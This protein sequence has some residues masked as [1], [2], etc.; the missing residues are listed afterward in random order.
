M[1]VYENNIQIFADANDVIVFD[2]SKAYSYRTDLMFCIDLIQPIYS[3]PGFILGL[4]KQHHVFIKL[5]DGFDV[6]TLTDNIQIKFIINEYKITNLQ[7][8]F[9]LKKREVI[10]LSASMFDIAQTSFN[11]LLFYRQVDLNILEV[12]NKQ[13]QLYSFLYFLDQ[14]QDKKQ[15]EYLCDRLMTKGLSVNINLEKSSPLFLTYQVL[16]CQDNQLEI[17]KN[18]MNFITKFE[19][20]LCQVNFNIIKKLLI[21]VIKL[22]NQVLTSQIVH[23]FAHNNELEELEVLIFQVQDLILFKCYF[24]PII[25]RQC[26]DTYSSKLIVQLFQ[27]SFE[28]AVESVANITIWAE[29]SPLILAA[30]SGNQYYVQKFI[31]IDKRN[32]HIALKVAKS[33]KIIDMLIPNFSKLVNYQPQSTKLMELVQ[34]NTLNQLL[35]K[36]VLIQNQAGIQDQSGNYASNIVINNQYKILE[37]KNLLTIELKLFHSQQIMNMKISPFYSIQLIKLK[38]QSTPASLQLY[39]LKQLDD[40]Q[41]A[42][43][44]FNLQTDVFGMSL[45]LHTL[46]SKTAD[47]FCRDN[48]RYHTLVTLYTRQYFKTSA[49]KFHG[50]FNFN[51]QIIENVLVQDLFQVLEHQRNLQPQDNIPD[52]QIVNIVFNNFHVD[53][54]SNSFDDDDDDDDDDDN[55]IYYEEQNFDTDVEDFGSYDEGSYQN[56]KYY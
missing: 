8:Q 23:R 43:D 2:D 5:Q 32:G 44:F 27:H 6:I 7:S 31:N 33:I 9:L 56:D 11:Q 52:Q 39:I 46:D 53:E 50:S 42:M 21:Q 29:N 17:L 1:K 14:F 35:Y 19:D 48:A 22:Q 37:Y 49:A 12:L 36:D 24:D 38:F 51:Q 34:S 26:N 13:D 30:Q 47:I 18:D 20:G 41:N 15:Y 28:S 40:P 10:D 16:H 3:R 45:N 55:D 54:S 25:L 4:Y